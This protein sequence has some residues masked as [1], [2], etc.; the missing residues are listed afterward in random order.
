MFF[1]T[2]SLALKLQPTTQKDLKYDLANYS[3]DSD[4][5][6]DPESRACVYGFLVKLFCGVTVS[7]KS[8]CSRCL[9]L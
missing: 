6:G 4:F 1:D 9:T 5:A 3:E 2:K 7:W 8:K